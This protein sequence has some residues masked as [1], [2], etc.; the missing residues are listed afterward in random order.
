MPPASAAVRRRTHELEPLTGLAAI[1][2]IARL[3]S[4]ELRPAV[5]S[6][7]GGP[8][9]HGVVVAQEPAAGAEV[10][11]GQLVTLIVAERQA[12]RARESQCR[13]AAVHRI[14]PTGDARG[15]VPGER[16]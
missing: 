8:E 6:C 1:D 3:R 5:E 4:R 15:E 10:A 2:A 16:W 9:Q 12:H 13:E 14:D 11:R 7:E